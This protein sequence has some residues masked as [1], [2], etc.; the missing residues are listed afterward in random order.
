MA[1]DDPH[2]YSEPDKV[3]VTH[4]GLDLRVDFEKHRLR[5]TATWDLDRRRGDAVVFDVRDMQI[6]GVTTEDGKLLPFKLGESDRLLGQSLTVQLPEG[7]ER[8]QIEYVTRPEAA[9]LQ[10]LRPAQTSGK[11]FPFLFT[12]S[13]AVLARSW[14]PCQDSPGVRFTYKARLKVPGDL[15]ALMSARNPTRKN[16]G[17]VY[18]FEMDQPIPSYLMALAVGDIE[19]RPLGKVTGIYAE[20]SVL[21]AAAYEFAD[22]EKMV[23]AA[24]KMYGPYRWGRYDM[25]VLPPSFPFGGMENP[26]LTFLT[27]TVMAGDRSLTSLIAHELAHSWSGNLVTNAS[28]NDFWLNEGFTVYLERRIMEKLYGESYA[29]MLRRLGYGDLEMALQHEA[30]ADTHLKLNLEGRDPDDGLSDIAYEKGYFFLLDLEHKVGREKFDR[31]LRGWF[32]DNAFGT[33]TTEQF[34]ARVRRD[35]GT[36]LRVEEW[37]YSAGMPEWFRPPVSERF[38]KVDHQRL[39]FFS[40][41]KT[42]EQLN[43]KDWTT[44]EWLRFLRYLP[45][46]TRVNEM[47]NLDRAFHFSESKNSEIL[48]QWLLASIKLGYKPAYP[49]LER[50]LTKVGRRKFLTP[51][52]RELVKTPEGLEL[53]REIYGKARPNYHSVST[54]TIDQILGW[55]H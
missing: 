45:A 53:A 40:G 13:Q 1:G 34:L 16:P 50:F 41:G 32:E 37:V 9:A 14:I 4:L 24:E 43:T 12:Q 28:W 19:F 8:I 29:A 17:G 42:A 30:P 54:G 51:L 21:D 11:K 27:P 33:V 10:W 20:P 2:S 23:S 6:R 35:L 7:V 18:E 44:H 31:F 48:A 39:A 25:L 49:A 3:R 26:R 22:T 55:E 52:Y 15:L 36:D 47:A 46:T 5:G 38:N